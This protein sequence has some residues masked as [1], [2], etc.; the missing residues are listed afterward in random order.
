MNNFQ[1]AILEKLSGKKA[2]NVSK[3]LASYKES[4]LKAISKRI[5]NPEDIVAYEDV[6][7]LLTNIFTDIGL[8][9]DEALSIMED[10]IF[11]GGETRTSPGRAWKEL[12]YIIKD[13]LEDYNSEDE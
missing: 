5:K 9:E 8:P 7:N 6:E 2:S 1:K 4:F 13:M 11:G 3:I 10:E 12:T